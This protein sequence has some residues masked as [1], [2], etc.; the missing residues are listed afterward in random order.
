MCHVVEAEAPDAFVGE[1]VAESAIGIATP[2]GKLCESDAGLSY[3]ETLV[4]VL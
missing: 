3:V 2:F 1:N 4:I